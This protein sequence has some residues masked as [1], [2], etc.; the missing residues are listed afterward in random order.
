M[1]QIVL[2]FERQSNCDRLREAL[3]STGEFTCLACR[4]AAQVKRA[5][6]ELKLALVVCGFKL[7]DESCE[8]LYYDLPQWC[9]M[10]MVAHQARLD[11][12][13]A[14]GIFKLPAPAA[15]TELLASVRLLAQLIQAREFPAQ[16]SP[17]ERELVEQAKSALMEYQGMTEDE[18]HRFLQRRSMDQR[19]RLADTARQV[20]DETGAG[21]DA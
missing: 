21:K 6:G 8:T 10:L 16:R 3:E 17:E 4:S 18:A 14:P 20:L 9:V 5:V 19:V 11:L 7:A 13:A 1:R 2:A 12:C 15:R